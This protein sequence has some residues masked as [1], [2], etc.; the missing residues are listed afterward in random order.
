MVGPCLIKPTMVSLARMLSQPTRTLMSPFMRQEQRLLQLWLVLGLHMPT[1]ACTEMHIASTAA[2]EQ[3]R[4]T[5][6]TFAP[7]PPLEVGTATSWNAR[8]AT[9]TTAVASSTCVL[10][11][12]TVI[13][14]STVQ[15]PEARLCDSPF[16]LSPSFLGSSLLH[17]YSKSRSCDHDHDHG[18]HDPG[19]DQDRYHVFVL[20]I[21]AV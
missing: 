16:L 11:A 1:T 13:N 8:S 20:M 7:S 2:A 6:Q 12:T 3:I 21:I 18:D 19:H 15:Q 9:T 4:L 5:S 17:L 14:C 10:P